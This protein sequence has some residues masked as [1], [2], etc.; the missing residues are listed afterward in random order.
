MIKRLLIISSLLLAACATT[1]VTVVD[2]T[3]T[4]CALLG[5][6]GN[7]NLYVGEAEF[8]RALKKLKRQAVELGGNVL[9]CCQVQ[10]LGAVEDGWE[11]STSG[12]LPFYS[13]SGTAYRCPL[14]K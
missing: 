14:Q 9:R 2:L 1:S 4:N 5:Q 8:S 13:L 3:P 11:A 6:V 7:P 12:V 10:T